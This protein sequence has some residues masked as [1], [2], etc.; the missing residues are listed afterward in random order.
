MT[1]DIARFLNIGQAGSGKR[2]LAVGLNMAFSIHLEQGRGL[3]GNRLESEQRVEPELRE[4]RQTAFAFSVGGRAVGN[5]W[6]LS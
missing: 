4:L 2:P 1:P 5:V 3:E 6:S